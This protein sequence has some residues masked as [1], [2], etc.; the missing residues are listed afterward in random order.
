MPA[1]ARV[2]LTQ[3]WFSMLTPSA[4]WR[5][6][7]IGGLV[8]ALRSSTNPHVR[9]RAPLVTAPLVTSPH[10]RTCQSHSLASLPFSQ[11]RK[12]RIEMGFGWDPAPWARGRNGA[13][14]TT[15]A[16]KTRL[17]TSIKKCNPRLLFIVYYYS[18]TAGMQTPPY[19]PIYHVLYI[20]SQ[21]SCNTALQDA[22][23]QGTPSTHQSLA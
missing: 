16:A 4:L 15:P 18:F 3:Q 22:I 7:V 12:I 11:W 14:Q 17:E 8:D 23:A 19:T 10:A 20:L 1:D 5:P 9:V 6:Q 13:N 2:H 21:A